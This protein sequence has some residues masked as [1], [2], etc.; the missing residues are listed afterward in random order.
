VQP[1]A[2]LVP[3]DHQFQSLP[4]LSE[5]PEQVIARIKEA[6]ELVV[7]I[8]SQLMKAGVHFGILPGTD[9]P[10]LLKDGAEILNQC[11][12]LTAREEE[13][14]DLSSHD[15][16]KYKVTLGIYD[17]AGRRLG[18]GVG[19]C[20][21]SEE[22]YRWKKAYRNEYDAT[23]VDRRRTKEYPKR[24]GSGGVDVT[25]QVRT[26]P[27]D[28]EN[29]VLQMATKRAYVQA[30]RQVHAISD[31]FADIGLEDLPEDQRDQLT[32]G[33]R[34][35]KR[36]QQ[37]AKKATP[38]PSASGASKPPAAPAPAAAAPRDR[39]PGSD[40][41][42][43]FGIPA[44]EWD[45]VREVWHDRNTISLAQSKRIFGVASGAGWRSGQVVEE[46]NRG[47]GIEQD[48]EGKF[49]VPAGAPY[50]RLVA[51]FSKAPR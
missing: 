44:E 34:K 35:V 5:R 8:Q 49:P 46:I 11:F 50:E 47:L 14:S 25:Y 51:I 36:P 39:E 15:E 31:V 2:D 43:L 37:Q 29:T 18:F 40:D 7:Q 13:V 41:G 6:R 21:T 42:D 48:D 22:K 24:D 33:G 12:R 17:L 16:R 4:V 19:V 28:M 20:S 9:K 30:T 1:V 38:P 45:S 23:A 26:E 10:M 32:I 27:A 3:V